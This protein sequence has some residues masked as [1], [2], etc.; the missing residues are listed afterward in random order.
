M[1]LIIITNTQ[2]LSKNAVPLEAEQKKKCE[3]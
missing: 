1:Y 2:N 3:S